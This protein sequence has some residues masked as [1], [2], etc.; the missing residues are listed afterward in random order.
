LNSLLRLNFQTFK[1]EQIVN[2]WRLIFN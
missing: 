2:I 1:K